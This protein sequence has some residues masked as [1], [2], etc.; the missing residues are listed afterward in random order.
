[1]RLDKILAIGGFTSLTSA[2]LVL[3][4][5]GPAT[6]YEMCIY[7]ACPPHFWFFVIAGAACGTCIIVR[8]A[9][10][11]DESSSWLIL[12]LVIALASLAVVF[13]LPTL[14]GYAFYS[15]GDAL[16]H[17]GWIL[18][19]TSTGY[20]AMDN[21][22]P[23][24]HIW[25]AQL[26]EVTAVAPMALMK[27]LYSVLPLL[28]PLLM[29]LLA[30]SMFPRR[31]QAVLVTALSMAPILGG[32]HTGLAPSI[33]SLFML[34]LV[35]YLYLKV[36][37]GKSVAYTILLTIT[38]FLYPSI[39]P[40]WAIMLLF[41]FIGVEVSMVLFAVARHREKVQ[42]RAGPSLILAIG[43]FVWLSPHLVFHHALL[44]VFRWLGGEA[45]SA[46]VD[47]L[48]DLADIGGLGI[49]DV[50]SL[51]LKT[52]GVNLLYA[53]L[54]VIGAALVLGILRGQNRSAATRAE[55]VAC[56][57]FLYVSI[58]AILLFAL[59]LLHVDWGRS[60]RFISLF[61]PLLSGY[62]LY[63]VFARNS[64][65]N[66]A[67]IGIALLIT[68]CIIT[69]GR[70]IHP[71]PYRMWP[72]HH[73]THAE[74]D[75]MRWFID[76]KSRDL[77]TLHLGV[78]G[79]RFGR[80]FLGREETRQRGGDL[81]GALSNMPFHFNYDYQVMFGESLSEPK[82]ML[83]SDFATFAYTTVWTRLERFNDDDFGRLDCDST[84]NLTYSNGN[85]L[86][87]LVS[88]TPAR[89]EFP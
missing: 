13:L 19:I 70:S 46:P 4:A 8:Q 65:R 72:G 43:I 60:L 9:L 36:R 34:P 18:D 39:H 15:R 2:L 40:L 88:P 47:R 20:F 6:G 74:M 7:S 53:L 75:G 81:G 55:F 5:A 76:Y 1:M 84:V 11:V 31:G 83:L 86:V 16:G 87:R 89:P 58:V 48:I 61:L 25:A 77:E 78:P 57:L 35:L 62:A 56:L 68:G 21:Y 30:A 3:A 41:T 37:L 28:Y 69:G 71:S 12:G 29:Y 54:S 64:R 38:L 73:V 24:M 42:I 50:V 82:Y 27:Y 79:S 52:Y 14:R 85:L 26:S 22:Y 63:Q 44:R 51:T 59:P 17:T 45:L 49:T 10:A 80:A 23:V 66:I 33:L 67:V 32:Y